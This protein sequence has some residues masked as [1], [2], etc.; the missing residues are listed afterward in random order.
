MPGNPPYAEW[1]RASV[2]EK[3][4]MDKVDAEKGNRNLKYKSRSVKRYE[5]SEQDDAVE[6][7]EC[8]GV[9]D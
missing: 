6:I 3:R 1:M 5:L 2:E 8:L 7:T 9:E 4:G